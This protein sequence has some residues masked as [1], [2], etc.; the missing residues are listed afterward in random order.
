M[1]AGDISIAVIFAGG[2]C[3]VSPLWSYRQ[4]SL[5]LATLSVDPAVT[6]HLYPRYAAVPSVQSLC[7]APPRGASVVRAHS[8]VTTDHRPHATC[9]SPHV[10]HRASG[11]HSACDRLTSP[12]L[13]SLH[14]TSSHPAA[15]LTVP[16]VVIYRLCRGAAAAA[17]AHP[18]RS[19]RGPAGSLP[20]A[21]RVVRPRW[22]RVSR[23]QLA[24]S[25]PVYRLCRR[26]LRDPAGPG[27]A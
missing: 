2:L 8:A 15:A 6:I 14:L 23:V 18:P 3:T 26:T 10:A 9:R 25:S 5:C 4:M 16:L 13:T 7:P 21:C 19:R 12:H 24:Q 27:G 17:A 11:V 1:T 22:S 20:G